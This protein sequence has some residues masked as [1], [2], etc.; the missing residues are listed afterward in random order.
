MA[1]RHGLVGRLDCRVVEMLLG[2][3]ATMPGSSGVAVNIGAQTVADAHALPRLLAMLD[4]R[5]A[6]A[7]RITFEMTEFG[8]LQDLDVTR[9]FSSEVRRRGAHFALDNFGMREGSLMLVHALR[10]QYIKLS[11]GYSREL[12]GSQDC[13]FLVT[14]LVRVARPLGIDIIAQAVDDGSLVPLL[15]EIGLAG[16]QGFAVSQPTRIV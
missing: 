8:A 6:L 4:A 14:S 11:A 13:R 16:Y 9:R 5:G 1:V 12:A 10:P 15:A 7:R 2:Y 3:L